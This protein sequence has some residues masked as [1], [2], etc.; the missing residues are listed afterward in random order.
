MQNKVALITGASRGIG[1]AI[2][3]ELASAGYDI[4]INYVKSQE[5]AEKLSKFIQKKY[6]VKALTIK[7]DVS[8]EEDILKLYEFCLKNFEKIDVLVNNA[9][10]CF[11]M[12]LSDR[13]IGHF[14]KTFKT[15]VFGLFY[16]TKLIGDHMVENKSG[17][18]INISSNNSISSFS[19]LSSISILTLIISLLPLIFTLTKEELPSYSV[20]SN[21]F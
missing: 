7:A 17:K 2:A 11:D 3:I 21:S 16:L 4:I 1:K 10:I 6:K 20:L 5:L 8:I 12:E 15:N 9:G 18:I 14:E 13:T 19:I